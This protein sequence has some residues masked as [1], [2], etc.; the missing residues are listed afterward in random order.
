M[1]NVWHNYTS[2]RVYDRYLTGV[3]TIYYNYLC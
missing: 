3:A 1:Y 2:I